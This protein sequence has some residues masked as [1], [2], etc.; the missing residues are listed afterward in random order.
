MT[1]N[2]QNNILTR[3]HIARVG[4][5]LLEIA[6]SYRVCETLS[7]ELPPPVLTLVNKMHMISDTDLHA[8]YVEAK[9]IASQGVMDTLISVY[10][11]EVQDRMDAEIQNEMD[12]YEDDMGEA[13]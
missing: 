10:E 7:V 2:N 9:K 3:M 4:G 6:A 13:A 1:T 5:T 8:G 11:K 12:A